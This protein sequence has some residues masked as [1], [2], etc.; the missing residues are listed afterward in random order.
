MAATI[1]SI[2]STVKTIGSAAKTV[3][4]VVGAVKDVAG[5]FKGGGGSKGPSLK[6][7]RG[8]VSGGGASSP[9]MIANQTGSQT[10]TGSPEKAENYKI[11]LSGSEY[12]ASLMKDANDAFDVEELT[13]REMQK[14]LKGDDVT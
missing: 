2:G 9:A 11:K 8:A 1:A 3:G 13:L 14:I 6:R 7:Y 5:V 10:R 12:V 4:S